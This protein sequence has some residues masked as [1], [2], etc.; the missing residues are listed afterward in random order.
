M[1]REAA[2]QFGLVA[3][4]ERLGEDQLWRGWWG[5]GGHEI[6]RSGHF[7]GDGEVVR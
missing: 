5:D 6:M 1:E 7:E 3:V 4:I 2:L